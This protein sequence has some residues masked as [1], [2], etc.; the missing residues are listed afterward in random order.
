M[1]QL[2]NFVTDLDVSSKGNIDGVYQVSELGKV[3]FQI[4]HSFSNASVIIYPLV[5]ID[6]A[7]FTPI[8]KSGVR[9]EVALSA[10]P[11]SFILT[12]LI[13]GSQI[14]IGIDYGDQDSGTLT[15]KTA[16]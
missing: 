10:S 1:A 13:P 7:L 6:G 11:T 2:K 16:G 3:Q 14:I 4:E 12:D 8:Y 9:L 15:I 5:S